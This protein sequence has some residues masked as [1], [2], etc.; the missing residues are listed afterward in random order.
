VFGRAEFLD[1]EI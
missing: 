1:T